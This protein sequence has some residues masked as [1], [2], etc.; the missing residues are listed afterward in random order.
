MVIPAVFTKRWYLTLTSSKPGFSER[1]QARK[2]SAFYIVAHPVQPTLRFNSYYK[3]YSNNALKKPHGKKQRGLAGDPRLLRLAV[4]GALL[5]Y[6]LVQEAQEILR[7]ASCSLPYWQSDQMVG[8]APSHC[9]IYDLVK[10][11]RPV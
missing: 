1:K 11:G 10:R 9:Q 2:W 6:G 4:Q 5:P 7:T 8:M 3:T